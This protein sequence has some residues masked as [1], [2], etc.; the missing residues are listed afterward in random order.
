MF[1]NISDKKLVPQSVSLKVGITKMQTKCS[2]NAWATVDA[3]V[4]T[5]AIIANEYRDSSSCNVKICVFPLS[6][7]DEAL[8]CL[9]CWVK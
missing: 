9:G 6:W 4:V 8:L 7:V 1:L 5:K 3:S 2:T